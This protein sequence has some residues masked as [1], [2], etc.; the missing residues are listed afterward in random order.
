M[1]PFLN[2][3]LFPV[4]Y[5]PTVA[6]PQTRAP[7]TARPTANGGQAAPIIKPVANARLPNPATPF[8]TPS[9]WLFDPSWL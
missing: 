5:L 4:K 2:V 3:L 8:N 1:T 9:A 6:I 7:P